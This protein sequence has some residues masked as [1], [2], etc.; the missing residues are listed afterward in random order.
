MSYE[1][2]RETIICESECVLLKKS[3]E[4]DE[5]G[6][7]TGETIRRNE[8][9]CKV[10]SLYMRDTYAAFQAGIKP[11]WKITVFYGDYDG[12]LS[13]E[14][15]GIEYSVYRTYAEGDNVELYLRKDAGTW[16]AELS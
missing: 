7:V 16:Q 2:T 15:E 11:A 10:S 6:V 12:E 4:T 14:Y 9:F 3:V 8:V 13:V 1:Y 5:N